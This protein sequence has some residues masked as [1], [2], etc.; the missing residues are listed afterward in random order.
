MKNGKN[1]RGYGIAGAA[2][3]LGYLVF[4]PACGSPDTGGTQASE[5]KQGEEVSSVE[6]SSKSPAQCNTDLTSCIQNAKN[7]FDLITCNQAYGSCLA[8]S[9]VPPVVTSTV[10][11]LDACRTTLTS[12]AA[13]A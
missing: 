7:F 3:T 1:R 6:Q 8:S 4:V 13:A 5:Q 11:N 9:L 2:A 12:C 10:N